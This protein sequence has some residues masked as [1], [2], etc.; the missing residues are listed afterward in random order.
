[1]NV[2]SWNVLVHVLGFEPRSLDRDS[3]WKAALFSSI[4]LKQCISYKLSELTFTLYT[5]SW[6]LR[7][8]SELNRLFHF[9]NRSRPN[10]LAPKWFRASTDA[11]TPFKSSSIVKYQILQLRKLP[12]IQIVSKSKFFGNRLIYSLLRVIQNFNSSKQT[13]QPSSFW[14]LS[15]I[16][17]KL[18]FC[19]IR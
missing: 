8:I 6:R 17:F 9:S 16:V 5:H 13:T 14:G 4:A 11:V 1:M 3:A 18:L 19:I 10:I 15:F 12:D 7:K 2:C